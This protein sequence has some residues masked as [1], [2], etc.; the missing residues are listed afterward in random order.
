MGFKN[1]TMLENSISISL[2][3]VIFIYSSFSVGNLKMV[4]PM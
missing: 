3:V 4:I 2:S 1:Y